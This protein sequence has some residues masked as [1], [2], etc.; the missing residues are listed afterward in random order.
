MSTDV[1]R[2][3]SELEH[4]LA[5]VPSAGPAPSW[6]RPVL[7][8]GALLLLIA[9]VWILKWRHQNPLIGGRLSAQHRGKQC[10]SI[11]ATRRHS[12]EIQVLD[13]PGSGTIRA[14]REGRDIVL[15]IHYVAPS[16]NPKD[17]RTLTADGV[18]RRNS[19]IMVNGVIFTHQQ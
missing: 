6:Q 13:L 12:I 16:P 17:P 9:I 15:G 1:H 7:A 3:T 14:K 8:L 4:T 18:M 11:D 2:W 19:T 10:G 5:V